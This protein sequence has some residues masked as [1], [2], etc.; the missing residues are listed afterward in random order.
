M[1]YLI[2]M[3]LNHFG[4]ALVCTEKILELSK[5]EKDPYWESVGYNNKG[6]IYEVRGKFN[7]AITYFDKS[8]EVIKKKP[9]LSKHLVMIFINKGKVYKGQGHL[10]KSYEIVFKA[11]QLF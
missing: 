8:Y 7:D 5:I 4:K 2:Y 6:S 3:K 11:L 9:K 1:C 10:K